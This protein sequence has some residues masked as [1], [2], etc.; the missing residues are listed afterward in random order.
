MKRNI[1][2]WFALG[3]S[4]LLAVLM[5]SCKKD[6]VPSSFT[7]SQ[8]FRPTGITATV[9]GIRAKLVWNASLFTTK[10]TKYTVE[11]SKD[12]LFSSKDYTTTVDTA[13]VVITDD[14]I[15]VGQKYF[16]RVKTN[17][18]SN[19]SGESA[20]AYSPSFTLVGILSTVATADLTSKT[21]II[22]WTAATG[23]TKITITPTAGGAS[24]DV[25]L[26][27]GDLTAGF[28]TVTGLTGNTAYKAEIFAGAKSKGVTTFTTPL[29]TRVL[30]P[31]DNIVDAVNAAADGDIIGLNKGTYDA[32]D[33]TGAYAA[34]VFSQ[35]NVTLTSVSGNPKDTKINFRE[36]TLKGTGAGLVIKG[37]EFDGAPANATANQA[38]YFINLVGLNAD[39]DAATFSSI[40][41]DNCLV[42]NMG[43]CF[44]RGNR[45]ANNAHKIDFIKVNN[46]IVYD[47]QVLNAYTFFT[48]DKMEFNRLELT[49]STF[50]N[51][52]RAFI[53]WSTNITV[54]TKPTM[55]LDHL[56]MNN[57]GSDSRD[58]ILVDAN[59]NL[60]SLTMTNNILANT[61]KAGGA[62]GANAIR[63]S[64]AG[65]DMKFTNND[66]FK[67][68]GG[69]PTT[70]P[71]A[72][73]AAVQQS[74]NKTTDL[75]WTATTT[76]FSIP[77]GSDLR[78]A[79]TTGGAIG[80][81]RWVK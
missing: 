31:T 59:A 53:S 77:A 69:S 15:N 23:L 11:V 25:A 42:H 45:A 30:N 36:L 40:T 34:I 28:K 62:V 12:S 76:D 29:Y 74:G 41:V 22:R 18:T 71:L 4:L 1:K 5:V 24:F 17:S 47:N 16:A 58:Y 35:K 7:P 51:I 67:F 57:F 3:L 52:G 39:A 78:T 54:A 75:G 81:P 14:N 73:P 68:V 8:N 13:G 19:G 48:M 66:T 79:S 10:G 49:N 9:T 37:I 26:T 70:A 50:Y 21:A 2:S 55:I 38:L 63:A 65:N 44:L 6:N 80:D 33:A 72:F 56:T 46:S 43:N 61:P 32:K 20:Y 27:A 60:L 64:N